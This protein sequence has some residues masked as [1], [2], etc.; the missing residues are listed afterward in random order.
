MLTLEQSLDLPCLLVSAQQLLPRW[1][2]RH[3]ALDGLDSVADVIAATRRGS[4]ADRDDVLVALAEL[5]SPD[6]GDSPEAA[7]LLCQLLIPAVVS[8][9]LAGISGPAG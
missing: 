5:A 2:E 6:G 4:E 1:A 3:P 9:L 8:T 7:A